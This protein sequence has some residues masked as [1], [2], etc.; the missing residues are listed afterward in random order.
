M[1]DDPASVCTVANGVA[2][3]NLPPPSSNYF[4]DGDKME[5]GSMWLGIAGLMLIAILM[6]RSFRGS[7]IIG[8]HPLPFPNQKAIP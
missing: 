8:V 4:C 3:T 5:S 7:I 1:I 2:V 6:S